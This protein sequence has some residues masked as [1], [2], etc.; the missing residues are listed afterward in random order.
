VLHCGRRAGD[1][2]GARTRRVFGFVALVLSV[3]D[4]AGSYSTHGR[5]W[6]ERRIRKHGGDKYIGVDVWG[7]VWPRDKDGLLRM[8]VGICCVRVQ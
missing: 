2:D 7:C 4:W 3:A 8:E 5:V 6:R 1:A